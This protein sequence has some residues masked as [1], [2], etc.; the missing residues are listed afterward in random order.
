M[1]S[2]V[3]SDPEVVLSPDHH[4]L[5]VYDFPIKTGDCWCVHVHCG[6]N[7]ALSKVEER[8][9]RMHIRYALSITAADDERQAGSALAE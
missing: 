4:S 2:C 7:E 5:A 6:H 9:L 3:C 8:E 1:C